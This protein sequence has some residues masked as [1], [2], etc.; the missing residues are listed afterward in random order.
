MGAIQKP[1]DGGKEETGGFKEQ[2]E[3]EVSGDGGGDE[4][5]EGGDA[6]HGGAVKGEGGEGGSV[7]RPIFHPQQ[8]HQSDSLHLQNHGY[9]REP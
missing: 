7:G 4:E 9:S 8:E 1:F 5:S 3:G 2:E 6:K